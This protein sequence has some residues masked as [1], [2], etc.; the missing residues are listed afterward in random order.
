MHLRE[1]LGV[2]KGEIIALVGAGGKTTAM[3]R[4]GR[5]LADQGW[6]V[7]A[8]TTTMIRP[9]VA[10]QSEALVVHGDPTH[11]MRMAAEALRDKHLIT[12]ASEHLV[13]KNKLRGVRPDL[14]ASL[15]D[16]ADAVII[17]ADGAKG[18]SLKAPA[19]HEPVVPRE[20]TLLVPVVGIDA[21]GRPLTDETVHRVQLVSGLTGLACGETIHASVLASLLTHKQGALKS[22][23][24]HAR[25]APL[26]NKVDDEAALAIAR[27]IAGSIKGDPAL[28]RVLIGSVTSDDPIAECWRRVSAVVL[29]A[30]ASTR[31]GLPKQ[32]VDVGGTTMIEHILHVVQQ[33]GVD[34]VVVV[35]GHKAAQVARHIPSWCR[36]ALNKRWQEGVSTSIQAG[37]DAINRIAQAVLFILADQPYIRCAEI[38]RLLQA[39]YGHTKAVVVPAY[40]GRR[41]N[42]VLF[43]RCLFPLLRD[44]RGDVGGRQVMER[45]PQQVLA[46][47]MSS[48]EM[49]LDIDTR[50]D[51]EAFLRM[52]EG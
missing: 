43:D 42:P 13:A 47:E 15:L 10:G 1:A 28:D 49:F 35:L 19:A 37:L 48:P 3:Y 23:P 33:T 7:V 50:T 36:I 2:R 52:R 16:L 17:E 31:F 6:R 45:L 18:R 12:L 44:L 24:A 32:L 38:D 41:G 34:E 21:V 11:A 4:L 30:G 8:T 27:Q 29:A 22:A 40:H 25:V 5:E 26:I 9:P 51:Y 20:T 14:A 39:Y 46:V